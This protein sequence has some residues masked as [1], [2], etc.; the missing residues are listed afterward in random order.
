LEDSPLE[1]RALTALP[2]K[3]MRFLRHKTG[4]LFSI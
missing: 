1:V 4:W 3:S 2:A